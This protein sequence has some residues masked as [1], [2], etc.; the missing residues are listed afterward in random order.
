MPI[1]IVYAR[2]DFCIDSTG[3]EV[4]VFLDSCKSYAK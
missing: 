1:F 4:E 2:L 3:H